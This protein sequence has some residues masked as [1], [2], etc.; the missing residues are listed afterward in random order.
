MTLDKKKDIFCASIK[1]RQLLNK[2]GSTK[3]TFHVTID[4][5]PHQ[6]TYKPG[7]SLAILPVNNL[8][9]VEMLLSSMKKNGEEIV[10]DHRLNKELKIK[11]FLLKNANINRIPLSMLKK[12]IH[13]QDE[14]K[15]YLNNNDLLDFFRKYQP[16]MHLHEIVKSLTKLTPRFYS[17][18]S[19]QNVAKNTIDLIVA[20]FSYNHNGRVKHGIGPQYLCY[21][22]PLDERKLECYIHPTDHF[23]LPQKG[24]TPI[25]MIGPGTGIA[26]FRAFLQERFV[27]NDSG[28][29][30]L[31]F[32]ERNRATDF[33]YEDFFNS[34]ESK[35][36]LSLHA[37]FSR[38][39]QKKYYVQD[40][41]NENSEKIYSL[42][43]S[44]AYVYICGDAKNMAKA[45]TKTLQNII[46]THS[47]GSGQ[48]E[49]K[50]MRAEKRLL[51]DVY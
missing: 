37:A 39:Q 21:D 16:E 51:L 27:N 9:E 7:D 43:K 44:G 1:D 5:G 4:T 20:T 11:D 19:S 48:D 46:D 38:D 14:L 47:Q 26:P 15:D 28:E 35:G 49:L 17:I 18:A 13:N 30:W 34:L 41:L 29:N 10:T 31:F 36:F 2:E 6:I 33:Y 45:V 24:D 32:G 8:E 50:K 42:I 25:I 12:V 40:L 23:T 22:L 3:K